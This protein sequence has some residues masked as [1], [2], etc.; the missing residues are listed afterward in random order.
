MVHVVQPVGQWL[1]IGFTP[2]VPIAGRLVELVA[3]QVLEPGLDTAA[4]NHNENRI[5]SSKS[6]DAPYRALPLQLRSTN[7]RRFR[8]GI[9]DHNQGGPPP[10]PNQLQLVGELLTHTLLTGSSASRKRDTGDLAT[11]LA[12]KPA[13]EEA[14]K[15]HVRSASPHRAGPRWRSPLPTPCDHVGIGCRSRRRRWF[16]LHPRQ[17]VVVPEE[18]LGLPAQVVDCHGVMGDDDSLFESVSQGFGERHHPRL[19]FSRSEM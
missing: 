8:V 13:T 5:R 3:A 6:L 18:P 4:R 15:E 17:S 11:E 16:V 9:D 14:T 19:Y 1:A 12:T 2:E 7:F 10:A